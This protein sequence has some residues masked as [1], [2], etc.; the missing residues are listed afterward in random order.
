MTR[1]RTATQIVATDKQVARRTQLDRDRCST[2][3][4]AET[5]NSSTDL[6]DPVSACVLRTVS[7]KLDR[8]LSLLGW[9]SGPPAACTGP[10]LTGPTALQLSTRTA[11]WP[12]PF[13]TCSC[14]CAYRKSCANR[15]CRSILTPRCTTEFAITDKTV[16][17]GISLQSTTAH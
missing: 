11:S 1:Q 3:Y 13:E 7:A 6:S 14:L 8:L 12:W 5:C 9:S 4:S 10:T 15:F 17:T 16:A 2:S